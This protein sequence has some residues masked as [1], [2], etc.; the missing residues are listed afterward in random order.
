MRVPLALLGDRAPRQ[1]VYHLVVWA[2]PSDPALG[3]GTW[4][5]IA[6]EIMHRTGPVRTRPGRRRHTLD[7]DPSRR[8]PHPYRG[9]PRPAGQPQSPAR[10]R[11][12]EDQRRAAGHGGRLR[13]QDAGPLQL[14][15]PRPRTWVVRRSRIALPRRD[16]SETEQAA[17]VA[18]Q[19][20]GTGAR[21]CPA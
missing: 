19:A 20:A 9:R 6:A 13:A 14:I 21:S 10:Q 15:P 3:D 5:E 17:A 7:R 11:L 1:Y 12:L 18:P 16:G 2:D 8:Q 4:N